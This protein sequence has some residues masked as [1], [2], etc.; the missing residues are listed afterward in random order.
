MRLPSGVSDTQMNQLA[1]HP[2]DLEQMLAGWR[3]ALASGM[4]YDSQARFWDGRNRM[5]RWH[6]NRALPIHDE[7][8]TLIKWVGTSTDIHDHKTLSE[9]LEHRVELRTADVR[10]SLLEKELLLKEVHHRVKN[11]L[12]IIGSLLSMQ[13][14][15]AESGSPV[16]SMPPPIEPIREARRRVQSMAMIHEHLYRSET[17]ADVDFGQ[18]AESLAM[19]LFQTYCVD[20]SRVRLEL[21]IEPIRLTMDQAIPCG[22]ILNELVSN[23]LKHAFND[24]AGGTVQIVFRRFGPGG[25]ELVVADTGA[26]L[27]AEFDIAKVRSLGLQVVQAL[28]EQLGANLRFTTGK[29]TAIALDWQLSQGGEL[30]LPDRGSGAT[31]AN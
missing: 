5:W 12:Q 31:H 28:S 19:R 10:R 11:N 9:E 16:G 14:D 26:G 24:G 18:Y 30:A 1:V 6:L 3:S 2:D 25:A 4:P 29:G 23:A 7:V 17:L 15:Y 13:I 21:S 27:P 8:G 22:L 20:T